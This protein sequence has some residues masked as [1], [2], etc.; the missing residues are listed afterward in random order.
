MERRRAIKNIAALGL[1]GVVLSGC[2]RQQSGVLSVAREAVGETRDSLT[3]PACILTPQQTSGPFYFDPRQMRRDITEGRPGIPLRMQ[4]TVVDA[5]RCEPI[6]NAAVDVWH[7]DSAGLYSGFGDAALDSE[8]GQRPDFMRGVQR[9]DSDGNV[10]FITRWPGWY[11]NRTV[12]VHFTVQ[13]VAGQAATSQ[14]YFPEKL[15]DEVQAQAPYSD[16][17]V[18]SRRNDNDPV[19]RARDLDALQMTVLPTAIGY[20]AWH[21]IGIRQAGV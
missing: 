15:N 8:T 3:P 17:G 21:T 5:D 14:L 9:T 12:H 20:R 18:R 13:L 2:G 4:L 11:P 1:G 19:L 6:E 10:E 16:R 7:A